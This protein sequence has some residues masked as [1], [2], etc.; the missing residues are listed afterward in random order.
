[1]RT[2][3]HPPTPSPPSHP[4]DIQSMLSTALCCLSMKELENVF[5]EMDHQK[6]QYFFQNIGADYI[7]WYRNPS[8]SSNMGGV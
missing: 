1:M 6:I 7:T 5:K 3:R 2:N 8:A 4:P